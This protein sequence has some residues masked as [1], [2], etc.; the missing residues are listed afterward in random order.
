MTGTW[1]KFIDLYKLLD[2][3]LGLL[4]IYFFPLAK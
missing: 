2:H 4:F 1:I 3:K